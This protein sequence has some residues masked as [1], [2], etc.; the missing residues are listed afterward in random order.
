M[1]FWFWTY[2]ALPIGP[3]GPYRALYGALY[4]AL[5]SSLVG[6]ERHLAKR[7]LMGLLTAKVS[8]RMMNDNGERHHQLLD[9]LQLANGGCLG[10]TISQT[11]TVPSL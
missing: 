4:R 1:G 11:P 2:R 7:I 8:A 9:P 5:F 6:R 10:T 3:I